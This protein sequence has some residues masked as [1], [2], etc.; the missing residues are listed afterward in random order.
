MN[1]FGENINFYLVDIKDI[2]SDVDRSSFE[3]ESLQELADSIIATGC[4]LRPMVLKQTGPMKF[5]VLDGHFEYHAAVS[6]NKKDTQR[7]L[8]GMVTAFV[9]KKSV[10]ELDDAVKQQTNLLN[11]RATER[12]TESENTN[13]VEARLASLELE[14][15]KI[16][17]ILS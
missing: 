5:K 4:L 17:K 13:S 14:V 2:E 15:D 11:N 3:E 8:S 1:K 10:L 7:V 16:K 6:A 9:L 12:Q